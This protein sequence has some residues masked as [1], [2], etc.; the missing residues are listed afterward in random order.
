MK[1]EVFT[2]EFDKCFTVFQ[3]VQLM[4]KFLSELDIDKEIPVVDTSDKLSREKTFTDINGNT[5]NGLVDWSTE[6]DTLSYET[7]IYSNVLQDF[8]TYLYMGNDNIIMD[9]HY[10]H[11]GIEKDTL[12]IHCNEGNKYSITGTVGDDNTTEIN[13]KADRLLHNGEPI[14][15]G[16]VSGSGFQLVGSGVLGLGSS[17]EA[18]IDTSVMIEPALYLLVIKSSITV[19]GITEEIYTKT[20]F[21]HIT[22]QNDTVFQTEHIV[23]D[24]FDVNA[25]AFVP[26]NL[27]IVYDPNEKSGFI[28]FVPINENNAIDFSTQ[29]LNYSYEL[30]KSALITQ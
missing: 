24:M 16:I 5:Y 18:I 28:N 8:S 26:Y 10:A 14:G 4:K 27:M 6:N 3:Q 12:D 20:L 22:I 2:Q 9:N 7:K 30:Y 17:T 29:G 11:I 21:T 13:I 15:G 1:K 23:I 19:E 25:S